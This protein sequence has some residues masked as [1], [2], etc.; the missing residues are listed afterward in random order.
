MTKLHIN[1]DKP[2]KEWDTINISWIEFTVTKSL[3]KLDKDINILIE[4]ND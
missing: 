2:P 4:Q 3:K 1:K